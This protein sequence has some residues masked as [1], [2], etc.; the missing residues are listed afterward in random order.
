MTFIASTLSIQIADVAF[1]NHEVKRSAINLDDGGRDKLFRTLRRLPSQSA[2]AGSPRALAGQ[3]RPHALVV[4]AMLSVTVATGCDSVADDAQGAR[5]DWG[6]LRIPDQLHGTF[7]AISALH[8]LV[9]S[10]SKSGHGAGGPKDYSQ[11]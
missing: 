10:A 2:R 3:P 7:A 11:P 6:R 9:E 4:T 5:F 1:G 8:R